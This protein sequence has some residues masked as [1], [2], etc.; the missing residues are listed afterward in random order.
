MVLG[1]SFLVNLKAEVNGIYHGSL[2]RNMKSEELCL[3]AMSQLFLKI[4]TNFSFKYVSK[5]FEYW[6]I[7]DFFTYN[8]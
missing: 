1:M 4:C 3:F 5:S 7:W 2:D 6:Q 8:T